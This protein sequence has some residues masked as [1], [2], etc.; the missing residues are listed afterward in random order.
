[1]ATRTQPQPA[2]SERAGH[3]WMTFAG[4]Y[5]VLAGALN[6]IWGITALAKKDYFHESGLIWSSLST[7]GWVAIFVAAAQIIGGALIFGR[8]L[9]AM[10][11]GIVLG[12]S[13]MLFNFATIGAYPLWSSVGLVCSALVLWAVTVHSDQ[14]A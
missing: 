14:L 11:F 2:S 10:I 12:M 4:T 1:M 5:L 7:W 8:R 9:G 6:L 13:G 3:G